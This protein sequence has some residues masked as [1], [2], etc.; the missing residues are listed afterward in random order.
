MPDRP[1]YLSNG[2][3]ALDEMVDERKTYDNRF[4]T[5]P[6]TKSEIQIVLEI[7]NFL[8]TIFHHKDDDKVWLTLLDLYREL[9]IVKQREIDAAI[10]MEEIENED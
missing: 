5:R 10:A 6:A 4:A 3:L 7:Q 1:H 2:L 9:N 8:S